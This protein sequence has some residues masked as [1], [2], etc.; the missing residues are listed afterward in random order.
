MSA[1]NN[2]PAVQSSL[3]LLAPKF[4][5]AVS[6]ALAECTAA[7]LD[8]VVYET[9]RSHELA[10]LY[11]ARGRT[12]IPPTSTVTNAPDETYTWHGFG[13]AVDVI[14][15]VKEW[16]MPDAWFA[17]VSTIFKRHEC[18]WGGDWK[19]RDLPHHQWGACKPSPSNQARALL[20]SGGM[21]AVWQAVGAQ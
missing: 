18:K 6:L 12:V 8:A 13:L 9:V 7:G 17:S 16:E 20:K 2:T 4:R 15:R 19:Q 11:Y 5:D 3:A 1:G 21:P 10:V 14:H